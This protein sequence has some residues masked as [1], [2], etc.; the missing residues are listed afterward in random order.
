M[1]AVP[2]DPTTRP[3]ITPYHV[4]TCGDWG[5]GV[6]YPIDCALYMR[7]NPKDARSLER[8]ICQSL[9]P[10]LPYSPSTLPRLKLWHFAHF[11]GCYSASSSF[12]TTLTKPNSKH[13]RRSHRY[14]IGVSP[15]RAPYPWPWELSRSSL[16]PAGIRQLWSLTGLPLITHFPHPLAV[17]AANPQAL[18]SQQEPQNLTFS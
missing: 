18:P 14:H 10:F 7:L 16:K 8:Q 17:D 12:S 1:F 3:P 6:S 9:N 4:L 13:K 11:S 2:R 15:A 5:V